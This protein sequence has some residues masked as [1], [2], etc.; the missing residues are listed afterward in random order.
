MAR[1]KRQLI[2]C[3]IILF[4]ASAVL[5]AQQTPA[6]DK[7]IP[8]KEL[9][10]KLNAGDTNIDYDLLRTACV[11]DPGASEAREAVDKS[12]MQSMYGA[13]NA[14]KY[15][16]ALKLAEA[17][18][19]KD[20][21]SLDA[22]FVAYIGARESGAKERAAFHRAVLRGLLHSITQGRDGRSA[23]TC[24]N[25]VIVHEEYIAL[26]ILGYSVKQQALRHAEG[27]DFDVMTVTS[28]EQKE[29]IEI[30]FNIDK[31]WAGY[32]KAFG[33]EKK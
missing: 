4:A 10:A 30:Y 31:L 28:E 15:D 9:T 8:C 19:Q 33:K 13:L 20:V 26:Q 17:L 24:W 14:D 22:R 21:I 3:A 11:D 1:M 16:E 2:L 6:S 5:C 7:A 12:E 29:P 27:H 18:L 25:A 23:A 32:D